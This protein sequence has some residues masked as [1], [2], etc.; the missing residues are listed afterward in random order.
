[1]RKISVLN[2]KGGCGKT[3]TAMSLASA[4]FDAGETVVVFDC[5]K[6]ATSAETFDLL[7]QDIVDPRDEN[8]ERLIDN[9]FLVI[10]YFEGGN[11]GLEAVLSLMEQRYPDIGYGIF[12]L[13]PQLQSRE[14]SVASLSDLIVV[15]M[16]PSHGDYRSTIQ[17]LEVLS[18]SSTPCIV[19]LNR[20]PKKS[21]TK[22]WEEYLEI[23]ELL[24]QNANCAISPVELTDRAEYNLINGGRFPLFE[25]PRSVASKETKALYQMIDRTLNALESKRKAA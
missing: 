16:L 22:R 23:K 21:D 8:N 24:Q 15:P 13:P 11:A 14:H 20:V 4:V 1:M 2:Q 19:L 10:P 6:Q 17:T 5:D 25:Y 18:S 9:S 12:D 7:R 3:V